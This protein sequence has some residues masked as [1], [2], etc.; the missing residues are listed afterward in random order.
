MRKI[1]IIAFLLSIGLSQNKQNINNLLQYGDKMFKE[2]DDKP[3]SGIVFDL[4]ETTGSKILEGRFSNGFRSGSWKTYYDSGQLK[5]EMNYRNGLL[6]NSYKFF[7]PNGQIEKQGYYLNNLKNRQWKYFY[8][9]GQLK[10]QETYKNGA[11]DGLYKSYYKYGQ[12]EEEIIFENGESKSYK[13][14][15]MD[16]Q[17]MEEQNEIN[18]VFVTTKYFYKT[19]DNIEGKKINDKWQGSYKSY[20]DNGQIEKIGFYQN[21]LQQRQ[22]KYYFED[23]QLHAVGS[24]KNGDG[25]NPGDSGIPTHGREGKWKIYHENGQLSEDKDYKDGM[26]NGAYKRY[27][28]NGQ[29]SLDTHLKDDE[30]DGLFKS[31]YENGQLNVVGEAF[32]GSRNGIFNAY[33]ENGSLYWKANYIDGKLDGMVQ[34]YYDNGN[35]E[36]SQQYKVGLEV[37]MYQSYYENG[38]KSW[39]YFFNEEGNRDSLKALTRW[40]EDGTLWYEGFTKTVNDSTVHWHGP[41]KQFDESGQLDVEECYKNNEEIYTYSAI[42]TDSKYIWNT[43]LFK[44][45]EE[46]SSTNILKQFSDESEPQVRFIPYDDPPRPLFPIRPVYPDVAQEAGIEGQVLIQC[47]IDKTGR[48]KET[49]VLKGIPNTGLDE[50][51]VDALRKTRFRPAEQRGENVGVWITIP[52][53]FKLQ[54]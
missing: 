27:Y 28:E 30:Y 7:Y 24:Y 38:N 51:A 37:G 5:E 19:Y 26:L 40:R 33:H 25:T 39:L 52:I 32:N 9:D 20:Y 48:V 31:Y 3:F 2:N 23:G 12:I 34:V 16:G 29:I 22:W 1:I 54:N 6:I 41:K 47:F 10:K 50:A 36:Y 11:L 46:E 8:E 4:S 21:N 35:L 53:N 17:I 42:C 45:S 44:S 15:Y 13:F 18:G 14:Y 43:K 49:I